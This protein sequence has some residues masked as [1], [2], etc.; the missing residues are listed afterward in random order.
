MFFNLIN[1]E[2]KNYKN[3]ITVKNPHG[4]DAR[5]IHE[6][7]FTQV[8]HILLK[9][10]EKLIKH[11]ALIDLFFYVLEGKGTVEIGEES[12]P[13]NQ[14]DL[15]NSP[16]NIPHMLYNNSNNNFRVLVVK[17]PKPLESQNKAALQN[18]LKSTKNH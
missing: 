3:N 14:D 9:P 13:V 8:V 11:A 12:Q 5:I 1:M 15:V 18:I 4:I 16:K 7:D 10:R 17:T 6:N 2:L